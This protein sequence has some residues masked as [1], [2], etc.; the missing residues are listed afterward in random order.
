MKNHYCRPL[1]TTIALCLAS[2]LCL[3]TMA[4]AQARQPAVASS[5]AGSSAAVGT[6]PAPQPNEAPKKAPPSTSSV[7]RPYN[8]PSRRTRSWIYAAIAGTVGV[9]AVILLA[10]HYHNNRGC[11]NCLPDGI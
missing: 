6:V 8:G 1:R 10:R 11:D 4:L 2:L 5:P 9:I 7:P 3:A